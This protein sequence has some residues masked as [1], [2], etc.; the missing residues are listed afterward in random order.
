MQETQ[1]ETLPLIQYWDDPEVPEQI[2]ELVASFRDLN[3]GMP[4]LLFDRQA[5]DEFIAENHTERELAAFRACAVPAMQADYF[6][7]CAALTLGGICAD[8]DFKCVQGLRSRIDATESALLFRRR[9]RRNLINGLFLFKTSGHELLRLA[10]DVCT[11]N[12]EL[13]TLDRVNMA[14]GPWVFTSLE[15]LYRRGSLDAARNTWPAR[16]IDPILDVVSDY[17]L[18]SSA[19]TDVDVKPLECAAPWI[20]EVDGPLLHK[21]TDKHWPNWSGSIYS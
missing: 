5:A 17:G 21:Q 12:I 11:R 6:R 10:R 8:A 20:R 18:L 15:I 1:A 13:R 9:P 14:T 4:C 19:F 2:T 7:Y 3:P 16:L